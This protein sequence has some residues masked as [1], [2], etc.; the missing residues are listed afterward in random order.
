MLPNPVPRIGGALLIVLADPCELD[1]CGVLIDESD[2]PL[3][4][5]DLAAGGGPGGGG[6]SCNPWPQLL[7]DGDRCRD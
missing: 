7:S 1:P 4:L 5:T 6:G 2:D 3:T